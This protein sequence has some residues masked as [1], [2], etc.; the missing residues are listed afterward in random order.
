MAIQTVRA[1]IAGSWY[2]LTYNSGT[3]TWTGSLTAPGAT[4][5]HQPGGYYSIQIEATNSA[6]TVGTADA[7][8]QDG[9]KLVVKETIAPVLTILSPTSGAYVS[10]NRQP[11]VCHVVD[12]VGGSGVN[13]ASVTVTVDGAAV[14]EGITSEA[15]AQ[16]FALTYTPPM[17][18]ADGSHTITW[19]ARDHDGNAATAKSTT[20]T[21]DTVPPVLNVTS[22][23]DGLTTALPSL[24]AT[25]TTNDVSSSPVTVVISL[26]GVS[27]GSVEVQ[28]SGAWSKELTLSSGVNTLVI[29]ATD[30]AGQVTSVSR[31]VTLDT[32]VPRITSV[33]IT[34][35]PIDAGQSM[36]I[37][38]VVQ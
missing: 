10:N 4:S 18:L 34:P 3:G 23:V 13:L 6:G 1:N 28:S 38:V 26:N 32:S 12:E 5:F 11:I 16:G 30:T 29:A 7:S 9:L 35:N 8:S 21:I 31:S 37:E 22:P 25:G 20:F 27:Q 19:N 2:N 17:A 24:I 36:Q 15:I 14:T 33:N